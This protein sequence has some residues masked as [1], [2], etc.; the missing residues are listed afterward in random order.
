MKIKVISL[1]QPWAE[2]IRVGAKQ[3]ETRS[4]PTSYRGWLAIH[5]AKKPIDRSDAGFVDFA[6]HW[7]GDLK[8][9]D[10]GAV[11]CI[12]KLTDCVPTEALIEDIQEDEWLWGNYEDGRFGWMLNKGPVLDV[13]PAIPLK[14][15]QGLFDW[16]VPEE[17][18]QRIRKWEETRLQD[19][20][21]SAG[22]AK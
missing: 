10:F 17:I 5:A 4:W 20:S 22:E 18:A 14:G 3:I 1:W 6:E 11:V 13:N 9:L 19:S 7:V 16:E 12:V 8:C 21:V 2:A 15:H